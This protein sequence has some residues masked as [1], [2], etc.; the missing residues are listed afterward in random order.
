[1]LTQAQ[2]HRN[3]RWTPWQ[4]EPEQAALMGEYQQVRA[5]RCSGVQQRAPMS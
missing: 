2:F 3:S 1:M 4:A 5:Q